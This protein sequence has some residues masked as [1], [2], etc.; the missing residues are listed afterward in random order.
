MP[1]GRG[2]VALGRNATIAERAM[3]LMLD[4]G[5]ERLDPTILQPAEPFL[6][7]VGEAVRSRLFLSDAGEG[8]TM[9]LRPE[10][11][12]PAA[13][14]YLARG[15]GERR[16]AMAGTVFARGTKNAE[17]PQA[18]IE[19]LGH[20]NRADADARAIADA[21]TVTE[22]L[23]GNVHRVRVGDRAIFAA[24]AT[25]LGVP[26][27]WSRRLT[28]S[29][30]DEAS[31]ERA[32]QGADERQDR[33]P[34]TTLGADPALPEAV[35][36]ALEAEDLSSLERAIAEQITATRMGAG[37]RRPR[38]IA[39]RLLE[40]RDPGALVL[41]DGD[42]DTLQNFIALSVSF[43]A[44]TDAVQELG[45]RGKAVEHALAM[46]DERVASL[47][48]Y[49]ID[50][51]SLRFRGGFGRPLDYYTGL[52]FEV[53]DADGTVLAAGGRYDRLLTMLGS[54][55]PVPAVGFAIWLDAISG[56]Q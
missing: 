40:H 30:G 54:A 8:E 27:P 23:G 20:A 14:S 33:A 2:P 9:C 10:F 45:V 44:V 50:P 24:V 12:V 21:I 7:L 1:S 25:S 34:E 13:R 53:V 3:G 56:A 18:G 16:L 47:R 51:S 22:A 32:L 43:D 39:A 31:L 49:G 15:R 19:A 35:R 52:V 48:A 5:A 4:R 41:G 46:H 38:E 11:T 26:A 55:E 36:H 17:L 28:R 37:A 42:R 29:F 6:D